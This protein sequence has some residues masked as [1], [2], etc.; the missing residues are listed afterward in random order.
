MGFLSLIFIVFCVFAVFIFGFFMGKYK[1][2]KT[3][4]DDILEEFFK[5][6]WAKYFAKEPIKKTELAEFGTWINCNTGCVEWEVI[7]C[8][9]NS[10]DP[11]KKIIDL[12]H[13]PTGT[14]HVYS[15]DIGS[16]IE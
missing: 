10:N 16:S 3:N 11:N 6:A 15:F 4:V 7:R 9:Y 14:V 5:R 2:D 1:A 12:K 8:R 13:K